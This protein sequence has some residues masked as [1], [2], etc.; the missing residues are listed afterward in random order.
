MY[1]V[2]MLYV[3]GNTVFLNVPPVRNV[4]VFKMRPYVHAA[5]SVLKIF[6]HHTMVAYTQQ[7]K[8]T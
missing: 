6:I 2:G 1:A 8:E 3:H 7:Q 4:F 5:N